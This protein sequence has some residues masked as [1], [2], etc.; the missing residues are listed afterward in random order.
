MSQKPGLLAKQAWGK[1]VACVLSVD[2]VCGY[3][4]ILLCD[5]KV[6]AFVVTVDGSAY[7]ANCWAHEPEA[8]SGRSPLVFEGR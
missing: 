8:A 2:S 6:W 1:S 7:C 5:Y 3:C 4:G